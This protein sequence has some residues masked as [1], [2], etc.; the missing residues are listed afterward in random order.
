MADHILGDKYRHMPA[1]IMHADIEPYHLGQDSARACPG[2]YHRFPTR[3]IDLIYLL[4]QFGINGWSLF[5]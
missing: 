4:K 5:N 1:A 2:L 3:A